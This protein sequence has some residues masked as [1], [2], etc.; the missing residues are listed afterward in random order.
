MLRRFARPVTVGVTWYLLGTYP[1]WTGAVATHVVHTMALPVVMLLALF[2]TPGFR[3][4]L[5]GRF[6]AVGPQG[7]IFGGGLAAFAFLAYAGWAVTT[8]PTPRV[9]RRYPAI[10]A[11][12]TR[13]PITILPLPK[14][15]DA[16]PAPIERDQAGGATATDPGQEPGEPRRPAVPAAPGAFRLL[17]PRPK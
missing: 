15:Q 8:L 14:E 7:R 2:L 16:P 3:Q 6:E 4:W 1:I 10:E 12:S 5:Q 11:Q 17:P 13:P 9:A